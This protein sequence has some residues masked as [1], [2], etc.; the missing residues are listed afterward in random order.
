M[1]VQ[2]Q[3]NIYGNAVIKT[4]NWK[5]NLLELLKNTLVLKLYTSPETICFIC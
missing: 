5:L 4:F 2:Y 3:V 1:F